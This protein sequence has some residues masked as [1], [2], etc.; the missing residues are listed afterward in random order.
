MRGF[1]LVEIIP[2]RR[3]IGRGPERGRQVGIREKLGELGEELEMLI[4]EVFR[5]DQGR[6]EI[7]LL[8]VVGAEIDR[9]R[10]PN[11]GRARL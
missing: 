4:G 10:E 1:R 7:D 6:D 5:H 2:Q 3:R 11:E 8:A 9:M